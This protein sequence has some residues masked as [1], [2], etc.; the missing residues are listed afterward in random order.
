MHDFDW[1]GAEKEFKRAIE[2]NAGDADAHFGYG[3]A[4]LMPQGRYQDALR[5]MQTARDL[6]PLSPIE[7]TYLGLA[8]MQVGQRPEALMKIGELGPELAA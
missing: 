7:T 8:Y 1:P 4:Y 3:I 5:E 6:D 2:L